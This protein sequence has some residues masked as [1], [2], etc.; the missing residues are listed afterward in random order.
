MCAPIYQIAPLAD[1]DTQ[2]TRPHELD[3]DTQVTPSKKVDDDK[4]KVDDDKPGGGSRQTGHGWRHPGV[5]LDGS[6]DG[7][8]DGSLDGGAR[9]DDDEPRCDEHRKTPRPPKCHRC[10]RVR[11]QR[12]AQRPRPST[13]DALVAQTQALKDQFPTEL[14][15]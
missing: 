12:E 15:S 2:V 10:K 14:P 5:V 9:L 7:P 1:S 8:L 3:D 11:E 13:T 6:I 4:P